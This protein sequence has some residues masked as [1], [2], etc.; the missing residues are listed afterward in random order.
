MQPFLDNMGDE[1]SAVPPFNLQRILQ[2]ARPHPAFLRGVQGLQR[3]GLRNERD[4]ARLSQDHELRLPQTPGVS[5]T[6]IETRALRM[7]YCPRTAAEN[8]SNRNKN[9][10]GGNFK[11]D[12]P[13]PAGKRLVPQP[14]L[15]LTYIARIRPHNP[16][17]PLFRR[18]ASLRNH[19]STPSEPHLNPL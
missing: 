15:T 14:V 3:R 16:P 6:T 2:T 10:D 9:K 12:L 1:T 11:V 5:S 13:I 19:P 4:E 18:L 17:T 7:P 8:M